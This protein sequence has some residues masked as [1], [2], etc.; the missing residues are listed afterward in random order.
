MHLRR[1]SPARRLR[2][3]HHAACLLA[4]AALAM[5]GCEPGDGH[6][7]S[8]GEHGHDHHGHDH[9]GH[10]HHGHD[11]HG[12]SHGAHGHAT[13]DPDV[14]DVVF[15]TAETDGASVESA[16]VEAVGG[17]V[18]HAGGL[19]DPAAFA[20]ALGEA[21][22]FGDAV[23]IESD[24]AVG[25]DPALSEAIRHAGMRG[26]RV[27]VIGEVAGQPGVDYVSQIVPAEGVSPPRSALVEAALAAAVQ[28]TQP[29]AAGVPPVITVEATT[30]E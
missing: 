26:V 28:S 18:T 25:T 16:V 23:I 27:I 1:F 6:S 8:H 20:A 13:N 21:T 7:H 19:E 22:R 24:P 11:H 9:H 17:H 15:L 29:D 3:V 5:L 2:P 4:A 30:G 12:H 10:D 14:L